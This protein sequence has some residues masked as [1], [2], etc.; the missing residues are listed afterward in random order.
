MQGRKA[1]QAIA[2]LEFFPLTGWSIVSHH[3]DRSGSGIDYHNHLQI[4]ASISLTEQ[5]VDEEKG[6]INNYEHFFIGV[7]LALLLNYARQFS[8][9]GL[10]FETMFWCTA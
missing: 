10:L 2:F 6:L 8:S 1:Q 7:K 3:P 4:R 9:I 5:T